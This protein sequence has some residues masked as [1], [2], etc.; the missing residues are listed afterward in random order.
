MNSAVKLAVPKGSLEKATA[1]LFERAGLPLADYPPSRQNPNY[2]PRI[3]IEGVEVK[4]LRPQEIPILL[5]RGHYDL[6]ISGLDWHTES[7]VSDNVVE[8]ADL[9]FGKID[10]VLAVPDSFTEVNTAEALFKRFDGTL[11]IWTEYLNIAA[12]FVRQRIDTQPTI[13]SPHSGVHRE[14]H[15][16]VQ[17]FHSF[18]ATESKP[19]ED[20]DA[21]I[22]VTETGN[23]LRRNKLKIIHRVLAASTARLYANLRAS[24]DPEKRD[25]IEEIR[26]ALQ[27]IV[28]KAARLRRTGYG[29]I[30]W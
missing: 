20:G 8:L 25:R 30:D 16:R 28:P 14:S 26:K 11:R 13:V 9:G 29:H 21:I 18:G 3:A 10:V 17:I 27:K 19:P 22:D 7:R 5:S 2:R 23:A 6:G 4:V 12:D 24:L 15:S 1:D